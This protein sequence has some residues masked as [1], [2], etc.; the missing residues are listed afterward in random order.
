MSCCS[1]SRAASRFPRIPI[2]ASH[3]R[4]TGRSRSV[5]KSRIRKTACSKATGHSGRRRCDESR[6][7]RSEATDLGLCLRAPEIID[8]GSRLLGRPEHD[9]ELTGPLRNAQEGFCRNVA[10]VRQDQ[11]DDIDRA[12]ALLQRVPRVPVGLHTG[13]DIVG[14]RRRRVIVELGRTGTCCRRGS[15]HEP[16]GAAPFAPH[17]LHRRQDRSMPQS[18]PDGSAASIGRV[19]VIEGTTARG[20]AARVTKQGRT[21]KPTSIF[22]VAMGMAALLC[23]LSAAAQDMMRHVDLTSPEMTSAEMTRADVEAAIA[24]ATPARPADFTGKKLSGLD[25]SGLDLS[26]AVLRAARL[27]GST[28]TGAT[29]ARAGLGQ[30]SL[31]P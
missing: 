23:T 12:G 17:E 26:G 21:M 30:A 13:E 14:A 24:A 5:S 27:N 19:N 16:R 6:G 20:Y 29:L 22:S 18:T 28:L 10:L 9:A 11:R 7:Q 3:T 15:G 1:R 8:R 2:S 25:L 4:R 31:P